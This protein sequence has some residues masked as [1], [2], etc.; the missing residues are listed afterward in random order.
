MTT[1]PRDLTHDETATEM[2]ARQNA[3]MEPNYSPYGDKDITDKQ[4]YVLV[5]IERTTDSLRTSIRKVRNAADEALQAIASGQRVDDFTGV[6]GHAV[7]DTEQ[8]QARVKVLI[9]MAAVLDIPTDKITK[10]YR[11]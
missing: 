2:L 9:E 7:T 4:R 5:Q 8:Q 11:G 3:D 10:V 6:F 1:T